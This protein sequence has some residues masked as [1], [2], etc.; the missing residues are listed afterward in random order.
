IIQ[1]AAQHGLIAL[2]AGADVVRFAPSL[3]ISQQDIK[4]GLARFALGI[5]QICRKT[6]SQSYPVNKGL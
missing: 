4:E 3:I 5:E 1:A 6:Q 2:I